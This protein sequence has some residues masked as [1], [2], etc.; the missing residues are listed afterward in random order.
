M[1]V[2]LALAARAVSMAISLVCGV[3]T[4]RLILGGPGVEYYAL[5]TLV[6]SL[7]GLISFSDLG[8]GAVLVNSIAVS[9]TPRKD[10]VIKAQLTTVGRIM[11]GFSGAGMVI[12]AVLYLTGA[13]SLILGDAGR[14][15]GA[16]LAAFVSLMIFCLG[17]PFGIWQRVLLGLHKNHWIILIQ[18][19]QGP[20]NLLL[21]WLL[22]SFA[23]PSAGT[24]LA[25]SSM[26]SGIMI[27]M[28]G[29][30]FALTALAPLLGR[31]MRDIPSFRRA[32]GV[33]VMHVGWPMLV[34][35]VSAPLSV[36]LLRYILAQSGT[37]H[38]VA[39]YGAVGQVFF[40]INGVVAAGGLALWPLFTRARARGTLN[41]GP[42]AI[43]ALFA[44]GAAVICALVWAVSPWLFDFITDGSLEVSGTTVLAFGLMVVCQAALYPLG[45]FLMDEA[46]IRFQMIPVALMTVSTIVLALLVTPVLGTAGPVLANAASVLV[47]QIVPFAV[48]TAR[49]RERLMG[50][51]PRPEEEVA[52]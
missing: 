4:V 8:S 45:M 35:L 34:Q 36:A 27:A 48:Y 31:A 2:L 3:L 23:P 41:R 46:G 37:T 5:Y 10:P 50:T 51:T 16:D 30:G 47:F 28:V 17:I 52:T 22:V 12:N 21:V 15:P 13:W 9:D 19:A 40:A 20:L 6:A 18:A 14:I 43:A 7:P 42:Y 25:L 1:S 32:P 24:F 33:Q 39:E 26:V 38:D 29:F 11:V 44:V 49:H